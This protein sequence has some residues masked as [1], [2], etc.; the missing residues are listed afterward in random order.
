MYSFVC[1]YLLDNMRK[2]AKIPVRSQI[3]LNYVTHIYVKCCTWPLLCWYFLR[4][5]VIVLR[6][7]IVVYISSTSDHVWS[8]S[9]VC[10]LISWLTSNALLFPMETKTANS[11]RI[12]HTGFDVSWY[13]M[14][15]MIRIMTSTKN[16]VMTKIFS[17]FLSS[18]SS[19]K[20]N[21]G[22]WDLTKMKMGNI[23]E[24]YM[25]LNE[26]ET[27]FTCVVPTKLWYKYNYKNNTHLSMHV[28]TW[29]AICIQKE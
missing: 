16:K 29:I 1:I 26:N 11:T 24:N 17:L 14:T 5:D 7:V 19:E 8:L 28:T 3:A 6:V 22:L 21:T 15:M 25:E 4:M 9:L 23:A 10:S 18:L 20:R 12:Q 2:F 27:T 13:D